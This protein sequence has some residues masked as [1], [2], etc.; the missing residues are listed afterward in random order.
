MVVSVGQDHGLHWKFRARIQRTSLLISFT[1]SLCSFT[2]L[3]YFRSFI[4]GQKM[5]STKMNDKGLDQDE[6]IARLLSMGFE[7]VLVHEAVVRKHLQSV[8]DAVE[9]LLSKTSCNFEPSGA[10]PEKVRSSTDDEGKM[11]MNIPDDGRSLPHDKAK[12]E[13]DKK[14]VI[15]FLKVKAE[16]VEAPLLAECKTEVIERQEGTHGIGVK[17]NEDERRLDQGFWVQGGAWEG[18][19]DENF[20]VGKDCSSKELN[21]TAQVLSKKTLVIG[22]T[23][24]PVPDSCPANDPA[25]GNSVK[26]TGKIDLPE[27]E[28]FVPQ[29]NQLSCVLGTRAT[30][31]LRNG[32]DKLAGDVNHMQAASQGTMPSSSCAQGS[33]SSTAV[34]YDASKTC[35]EFRVVPRQVVQPFDNNKLKPAVGMKRMMENDPSRNTS[36]DMRKRRAVTHLSAMAII[37]QEPSLAGDGDLPNPSTGPTSMELDG[38]LP[39]GIRFMA[40]GGHSVTH[41]YLSSLLYLKQ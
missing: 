6:L 15:S 24:S 20:D 26:G 27:E 13:D 9:Y 39:V 31:V 8:D 33:P 12:V 4:K 38:T 29:G 36:E 21:C 3:D 32:R 18:F 2:M 22:H 28:R 25:E 37:K 11:S 10:S 1:K 7:F 5:R 34:G 30:K 16:P 14:E 23:C 40:K 35:Q 17:E 41:R 19:D